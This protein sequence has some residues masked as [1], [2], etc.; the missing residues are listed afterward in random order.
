MPGITTDDLIAAAS[1]TRPD[2]AT[3]PTSPL[4]RSSASPSSAASSTNTNAPRER[5]G[6]GQYPGSG[7][8]QGIDIDGV[9]HPLALEE[10]STENAT[11]VTDLIPGLRERGLDVTKPIL[12]VLDG[13]RVS[14][15]KIG[16]G[17][18][19]AR[20][21]RASGGERVFVDQAAQDGLSADLPCIDVGHGAAGGVRFAVG[22]TLG[23]AWCGRAVL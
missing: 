23:D 4:S 14:R 21:L 18:S 3:P 9:K 5:P 6:Q 7:T 22:D 17:S 2:P 12:A 1:S 15:P 16:F 10:G 13:S 19:P 20:V 8:S 11:L